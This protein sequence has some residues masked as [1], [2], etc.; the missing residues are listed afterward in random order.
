MMD[1]PDAF[2]EGLTLM[3]LLIALSLFAAIMG[4]LMNSF[5]QFQ[6]Q[7]DRMTSILSLRQEARTLERILREDLQSVTYLG[8]FMKDPLNEKDDR[9]SGIYGINGALGEKDAD[10][11]HMHVGHVSRFYRSLPFDKDPELHE[12][13]YFLE[14]KDDGGTRFKRREEFYIDNNIAEGDR[15][16][17]H[18]LSENIV[19]FNIK[20]Y[21]GSEVEALD[22][23]DS[24]SYEENKN[25][26]YKIPAAIEIDLELKGKSGEILKSKLQVNLHPYMGLF[27]TWN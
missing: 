10:I 22:D 13:S 16:V 4:L 20:Y 17:I 15:S 26:A 27:A 19:S 21:R 3:E 18:T 8:E 6:S 23:W 25:S 7:N 14:E 24:S 2:D 1:M 12:V 5:F 9:K 11:I